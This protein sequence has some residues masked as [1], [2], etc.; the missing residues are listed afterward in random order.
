MQEKNL[1]LEE[2]GKIM[3]G[4]MEAVSVQVLIEMPEGTLETRV[5]DNLEM[6][7]VI[8][9]Y[10]ILNAI[11]PVAEKIRGEIT[12]QLSSVEWETVVDG[13]LKMVKDEIMEVS[14]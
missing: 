3:D 6:G 1:S 5:T 10:A 11:K 4:I 2:Y 9:F 7:S 12:M 8:Q 14:E 13:M